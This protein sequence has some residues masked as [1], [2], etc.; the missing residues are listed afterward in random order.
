MSQLSGEQMLF[1][2]ILLGFLDTME[3]EQCRL[4]HTGL[5]K[6]FNCFGTSVEMMESAGVQLFASDGGGPSLLSL[7]LMLLLFKGRLFIL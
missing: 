3:G 5:Q 2:L 1:S 4:V 7:N 6:S